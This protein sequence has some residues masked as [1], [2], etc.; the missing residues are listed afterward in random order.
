M[1]YEHREYFQ[2]GLLLHPPVI[3]CDEPEMVVQQTTDYNAS[4]LHGG[5]I[6]ASAW[7]HESDG[8]VLLTVVNIADKTLPCELSLE[9]TCALSDRGIVFEGTVDGTAQIKDG[10]LAL[11]LPALSVIMAVIPAE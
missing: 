5:P 9:Y 7:K 1:R 4:A 10:K 3:A 11:E 2:H 8:S 6:A